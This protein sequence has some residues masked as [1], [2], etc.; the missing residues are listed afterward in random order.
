M[1][2]ET[3]LVP[4]VPA[5][6]R[7][8]NHACNRP[9]RTLLSVTTTKPSTNAMTAGAVAMVDPQVGSVASSLTISG[10]LACTTAASQQQQQLG[11]CSI[12]PFPLLKFSNAPLAMAYAAKNNKDCMAMLVSLHPSHPKVHWKARLPEATL[13]TI[14]RLSPCGHYA[15][16]GGNSGCL[17]I[18]YTLS[19]E[20]IQTVRRAHYRAISAMCFVGDNGRF[21]VTGGQDGM[22]HL[23]ALRDMVQ[24]QQQQVLPIRTWAQHAVPITAVAAL[25]ES[26]VVSAS[27]DGMILVLET[28]SE[29][30]LAQIQLPQGVSS[31]TIRHQRIYAGGQLGT[32]FCLDMDQYSLHQTIQLGARVSSAS[33]TTPVANQHQQQ[34]SYQTTLTGHSEAVTAMAAWRDQATHTEYVASGDAMG[35]LR[36]WDVDSRV[37]VRIVQPWNATNSNTSVSDKK[38]AGQQHSIASVTVI[39]LPD[40]ESNAGQSSNDQGMFATKRHRG[41]KSRSTALPELLPPLQKYP[42]P[43]PDAGQVK[44]TPVMLW[45]S[46]MTQPSTKNKQARA[47]I[48]LEKAERFRNPWRKRASERIDTS[49]NKKMTSDKQPSIERGDD[50]GDAMDTTGNNKDQEGELQRLREQLLAA[51]KGKDEELQRLRQQLEESNSTID[52]WQKVNNEL[53]AKLKK[54]S[55]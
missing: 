35:T 2:P 9:K 20:L 5:H 48:A 34:L 28:F 53:V 14:L 10:D 13:S 12:S 49:S 3:I 43:P 45:Q 54:K 27:Q 32:I 33:D 8:A 39:E 19:G 31:L 23:W 24:S 42:T 41:A 52:R 38:K 50:D 18:W 21:L 55:S 51:E 36:I 25:S 40:E 17:Y 44:W 37:C 29:Q 46:N 47:D 16:A 15:I 11:V 7:D 22:V 6:L 30:V 26:R 1:D 4:D